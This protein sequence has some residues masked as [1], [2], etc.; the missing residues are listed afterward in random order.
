MA[1][2]HKPD[3]LKERNAQKKLEQERKDEIAE[4][5]DALMEIAGIIS[6]MSL[7]ANEKEGGENG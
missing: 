4:L 6:E 5:Q 2:Y 1:V 3:S 7:P